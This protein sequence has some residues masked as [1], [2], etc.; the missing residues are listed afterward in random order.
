[1]KYLKVV[2]KKDLKIFKVGEKESSLK[3]LGGFS[4]N[5]MM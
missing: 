2:K 3:I 1:M 4:S 5:N